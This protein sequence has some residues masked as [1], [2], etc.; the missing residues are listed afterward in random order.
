M[1]NEHVYTIWVKIIKDGDVISSRLYESTE[2]YEVCWDQVSARVKSMREND[3]DAS[4]IQEFVNAYVSVHEEEP[5]SYYD[6]SPTEE[7]E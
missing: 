1:K 6:D 2:C 5:I 7:E 3:P 4:I